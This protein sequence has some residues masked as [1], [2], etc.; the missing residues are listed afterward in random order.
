MKTLNEMKQAMKMNDSS[1][2]NLSKIEQ[3]NIIAGSGNAVN[4]LSAECTATNGIK[5]NCRTV[6][7]L[8][9][10]ACGWLSEGQLWYIFEKKD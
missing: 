7:G 4:T 9:T 8:F 5:S 3:K 10:W 6:G 1:M 2:S